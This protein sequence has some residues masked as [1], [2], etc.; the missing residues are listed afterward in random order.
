ME[1]FVLHMF[2]Y[3]DMCTLIGYLT[4]GLVQFRECQDG[5]ER[6]AN[7]VMGIRVEFN[8]FTLHCIACREWLL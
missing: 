1:Y 4:M 2:S 3:A 6:G 7:S 8:A 5:A